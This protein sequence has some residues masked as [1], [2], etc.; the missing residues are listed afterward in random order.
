MDYGFQGKVALVTGSASQVGMGNAICLT[1]AREGCDIVSVDL[2][3]VGAQKTA[4]AVKATGRKA[5]A[6][7]MD[8]A[9][10]AEVDAA[11]F[12]VR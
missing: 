8:V 1:L 12:T 9:K 10:G 4:D 11:L 7:K 3:L 6:L 5:I 2:D